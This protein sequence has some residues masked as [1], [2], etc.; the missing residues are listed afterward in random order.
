MYSQE[1]RILANQQQPGK[2]VQSA[3]ALKG[4]ASGFWSDEDFVDAFKWL[5]DSG[6]ISYSQTIAFS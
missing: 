2:V 4:A 3:N 5:A 1:S 6:I